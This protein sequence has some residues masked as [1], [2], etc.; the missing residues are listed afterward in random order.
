MKKQIIIKEEDYEAKSDWVESLN[1]I[2]W[3]HDIEKKIYIV[4]YKE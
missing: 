1:C 3:V 4:D 2:R